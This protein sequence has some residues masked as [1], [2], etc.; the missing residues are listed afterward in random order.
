MKAN[1]I[2]CFNFE[3]TW[4]GGYVNHPRDPGGA[5]N[6][7]A[8]QRVYDAYRRA[9]GA[10]IQ[11]V[12]LISNI[13]VAEI[14]RRQYWDVVRGDE[15]PI[16]VDAVVFDEAVNSG[17][18]RA[19]RRLQAALGVKVD[20]NLGMATMEAVRLADPMKLIVTLISQRNAFLRSLKTFDVFGKGWMRRTSA[21]RKTALLMK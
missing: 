19:I 13:E 9:K 7:G 3:L 8:T 4:E 1:Y 17:P 14:Y 18:G 2:N 15:L 5:T 12:K 16:G 11:S 6:K 10:P 21:L 20:G